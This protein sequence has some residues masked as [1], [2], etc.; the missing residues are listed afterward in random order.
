MKYRKLIPFLLS[1][2]LFFC[3]CSKKSDELTPQLTSEQIRSL[4]GTT[5]LLQSHSGSAT[6]QSNGTTKV[7]SSL[8]YADAATKIIFKDAATLLFVRK[9]QKEDL[10][11][12]NISGNELYLSTGTLGGAYFY[13]TL[14]TNSL[15]LLLDAERLTKSGNALGFKDFKVINADI[16]LT[17]RK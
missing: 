2:C 7:Q 1:M 5:W 10:N 9:D 14:D 12:Y 4:I 15:V 3:Q 11:A 6:N 17:Y 13:L 8:V 16:K